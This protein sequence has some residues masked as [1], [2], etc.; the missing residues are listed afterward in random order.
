MLKVKLIR[1]V[2]SK[3][4]TFE[5]PYSYLNG[6]LHIELAEILVQKLTS[7]FSNESLQKNLDPFVILEKAQE[8]LKI[9]EIVFKNEEASSQDF[10]LKM[11]INE[12]RMTISSFC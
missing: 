8:S 3:M 6:I 2:I 1:E 9:A 12:L 4:S 10:S 5:N 7:M 11:K